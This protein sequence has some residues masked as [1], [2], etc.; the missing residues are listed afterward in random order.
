M[1]SNERLELLSLADKFKVTD[2]GKGKYEVEYDYCNDGYPLSAF[3][4][5]DGIEYCVSGVY[6]N[7]SDYADIDVKALGELVRFCKMITKE[8]IN[9]QTL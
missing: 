5:D 9:E 6:N 1:I 4:D 7:S 3:I 2:R 8:E